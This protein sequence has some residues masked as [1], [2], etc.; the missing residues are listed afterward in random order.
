MRY[1]KLIIIINNII[2]II[3]ILGTSFPKALEI[4]RAGR[5]KIAS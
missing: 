4:V 5:E 1:T 2:F 3:I